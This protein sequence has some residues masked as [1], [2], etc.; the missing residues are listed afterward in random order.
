MIPEL[1]SG[2]GLGVL[3]QFLRSNSKCHELVYLGILV[4]GAFGVALIM[5]NNFS[6]FIG[7]ER[8]AAWENV[9]KIVI[10]SFSGTQGTSTLANLAKSMGANASHPL[11]PVTNSK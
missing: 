3:L 11:V 2:V 9:V 10:G 5:G 6:D 1:G 7:P 4:A 8:K